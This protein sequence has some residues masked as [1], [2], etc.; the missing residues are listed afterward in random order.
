M[1]RC[2]TG[3]KLRRFL[4]EYFE[5][6]VVYHLHGKTGL[7]T[8]WINGKQ[9]YSCRTGKFPSGIAFTI[10]GNQFH[11]PENDCETLKLIQSTMALEMLNTR[12]SLPSR[13][14]LPTK[15]GFSRDDSQ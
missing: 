6:G 8:V 15:G 4:S 1:S 10:F 7:F 13:L 9:N 5:I 11:L 3:D 12:A 2:H 14:M